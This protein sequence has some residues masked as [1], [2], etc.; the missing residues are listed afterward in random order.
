MDAGLGAA[1]LPASSSSVGGSVDGGSVTASAAVSMAAAAPPAALAASSLADSFA[2]AAAAA[3]ATGPWPP[4]INAASLPSILAA[5]AA[6]AAAAA[7]ITSTSS[8]PA[9]TRSPLFANITDDGFDYDYYGDPP[10]SPAASSP[11]LAGSL[12]VPAGGEDRAFDRIFSAR[13]SGLRGSTSLFDDEDE[14]DVDDDDVDDEEGDLD[15]EDDDEFNDGGQNRAAVEAGVVISLT[16]E[17]PAGP[18]Q[19][20]LSRRLYTADYANDLEDDD[21]DDGSQPPPSSLAS[22]RP[23]SNA[24]LERDW[25]KFEIVPVPGVTDAPRGLM[26]RI[27]A[28]LRRKEEELLLKIQDE[29]A[30]NQELTTLEKKIMLKERQENERQREQQERQR[31]LTSDPMTARADA[32]KLIMSRRL[33]NVNP[34]PAQATIPPT[35]P[36]PTTTAAIEPSPLASAL[37]ARSQAVGAL[38]D[39]LKARL[40]AAASSHQPPLEPT[41]TPP[42]VPP[43]A[44]PPNPSPEVATYSTDAA[45]AV[46]P[47][48]SAP[49]PGGRINMLAALSART[50]RQAAPL[51]RSVEFADSAA[52]ETPVGVVSEAPVEQSAEKT[53]RDAGAAEEDDSASIEN[54]EIWSS[55]NQSIHQRSEPEAPSNELIELLKRRRELEQA[56]MPPILASLEPTAQSGAG[57]TGAQSETAVLPEYPRPIPLTDPS[58]ALSQVS[59]AGATVAGASESPPPPPPPSSAAARAKPRPRRP[60]VIP[61]RRVFNMDS[62]T[63]EVFNNSDAEFHYAASEPD[64]EP[65]AGPVAAAATTAQGMDVPS[66]GSS[67]APKALLTDPAAMGFSAAFLTG[68]SGA[69]RQAGAPAAAPLVV[70]DLGMAELQLKQMILTGEVGTGA[71]DRIVRWVDEVRS[72]GI[73]LDDPLTALPP[74]VTAAAETGDLDDSDWADRLEPVD[75]SPTTRLAMT[76]MRLATTTA[77]EHARNLDS[78]VTPAVVAPAPQPPQAIQPVQPPQVLVVSTPAP[79]VATPVAVQAVASASASTPP[80]VRTIGQL[81]NYPTSTVPSIAIPPRIAKPL[82][83]AQVAPVVHLPIPVPP[84]P[85]P[86]SQQQAAMMQP[87]GT[88]AA[89]PIVSGLPT[90]VPTTV[91]PQWLRPTSVMPRTLSMS[92][93]PRGRAAQSYLPLATSTPADAALTAA[94]LARRRSKSMGRLEEPKD[95]Y[96]SSSSLPLPPPPPPPPDPMSTRVPAGPGPTTAGYA[97]Q[98]WMLRQGVGQQTTPANS[99]APLPAVPPSS[100][101]PSRP[102]VQAPVTVTTANEGSASELQPPAPPPKSSADSESP[103]A[104]AGEAPA[105]RPRASSRIRVPT[106]STSHR[107][108][109]ILSSPLRAVAD[110]ASLDSFRSS[111]PP[112][113]R[114]SIRRSM[115]S[116]TTTAPPTQRKIDLSGPISAPTT[117]L[118]ATP[119]ADQANENT[120][121]LSAL[122]AAPVQGALPVLFLHHGPVYHI[123]STTVIKRRYLFLFTDVLVLAK[124]VLRDGATPSTAPAGADSIYQVRAVIDLRRTQLR[125]RVRLPHERTSS[126]MG[127]LRKN[128]GGSGTMA[129]AAVAARQASSSGGLL[130]LAAVGKS[131]STPGGSVRSGDTTNSDNMRRRRAPPYVTMSGP[132]LTRTLRRFRADATQT[133]AHLIM[134]G[135]LDPDDVPLFL[136]AT[137][138]LSA[139][140]LGR[141][142]V[143]P[144]H[145]AFLDSWM[146]CVEMRSWPLDE[147]L[148]GVLS[149]V[150]IDVSAPEADGGIDRFLLAFARRWVASQDDTPPLPQQQSDTAAVTDQPLGWWWWNGVAK[151]LDARIRIVLRMVFSILDVNAKVQQQRAAEAAAASGGRPPLP[152]VARP[153]VGGGIAAQRPVQQQQWSERNS[154][155]FADHYV[156]GV[157]QDALVVA[158]AGA[159]PLTGPQFAAHR[160]ALATAVAR[161]HRAITANP[162]KMA[163]PYEEAPSAESASNGVNYKRDSEE[164]AAAAAAAASRFRWA[165]RMLVCDGTPTMPVVSWA[166]E[167]AAVVPQVVTVNELSEEVELELRRPPAAATAPPRYAVRVRAHAVGNIVADPPELTLSPTGSMSGKF[168]LRA[169]APGRHLVLFTALPVPAAGTDAVAGADG[170]AGVA[171]VPAPLP[172]PRVARLPGV[173]VV[174]EPSHLRHRFQLTTLGG[175]AVAAAAA[176]PPLSAADLPRRFLFSVRKNDA[177]AMWVGLLAGMVEQRR[178]LGEAA[179]A[180]AANG[181]RSVEKTTAASTAMVDGGAAERFTGV[182]AAVMRL[183]EAGGPLPMATLVDAVI[184][185]LMATSA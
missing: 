25:T 161:M 1:A 19:Q 148:R 2:A 71:Y 133:L 119:A 156:A 111:L 146:G 99:D 11:S 81:Q 57:D 177:L 136:H 8:E 158:A 24:L 149:R 9:A 13:P 55:W 53:P 35:A 139:G 150:Y 83:T 28:I 23:E 98:Y 64:A 34:G 175:G 144:A 184:R 113:H 135:Q 46:P 159:A 15:D 100:A 127:S 32:I 92:G 85:A 4:S 93:G 179:G 16:R 90:T 102:S 162:L 126:I 106:R 173:V 45:P 12:L 141:F 131:D 26:E 132:T 95:A 130:G 31:L 7:P 60:L 87:A 70:S 43:P 66:R 69:I 163:D 84:P 153:P 88:A 17:L 89:M 165:W 36:A 114:D 97:R 121:A 82:P 134:R 75:L 30:G 167:P 61:P 129:A 115:R 171:T 27:S 5:A 155:A 37:A 14:D 10:A 107:V 137:P 140:A 21:E 145:A 86:H 160:R 104:A 49:P 169:A 33:A 80:T 108:P 110:A 168:R 59:A 3:A 77:R 118:T 120:A 183:T 166:E 42:S 38:S 52:R 122:K 176:D 73:G 40:A 65:T 18:I 142:L 58:E 68:G 56:A 67:L 29:A 101:T 51:A 116:R 94:K 91:T 50:N 154:R 48:A 44:N 180:A 63:H 125:L 174:A 138:G 117:P 157:L 112:Q 22:S 72:F 123:Q 152:G 164:A 182:A 96:S 178:R 170:V 54:M 147:A 74:A 62:P 124:R 109:E 47:G 20:D 103:A 185:V 172:F 151:M 105:H 143:H 6:A 78:D 79:S 39:R 41:K 76:V 128:V 181:G